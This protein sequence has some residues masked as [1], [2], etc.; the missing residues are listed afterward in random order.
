[1]KRLAVK[2]KVFATW[3]CVLLVTAIDKALLAPPGLFRDGQHVKV[4]S[5]DITQSVQLSNELFDWQI[6]K[7]ERKVICFD[8]WRSDTLYWPTGPSPE[9]RKVG[10]QEGLSLSTDGLR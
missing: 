3:T 5:C 9:G 8:L 4:F 1:M 10:S 6:Y 7:D 2:P